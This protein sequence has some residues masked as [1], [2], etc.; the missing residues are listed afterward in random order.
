MMMGL[1]RNL[2]TICEFPCPSSLAE[3]SKGFPFLSSAHNADF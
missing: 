3:E 2:K 1:E